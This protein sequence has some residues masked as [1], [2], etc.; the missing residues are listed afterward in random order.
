M[1]QTQENCC[2]FAPVLTRESRSSWLKG[3]TTQLKN[4]KNRKKHASAC[5]MSQHTS[6]VAPASTCNIAISAN[7]CARAWC[8]GALACLRVGLS[9]VQNRSLRLFNILILSHPSNYGRFLQGLAV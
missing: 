6:L 7:R 4:H 9:T 8:V 1:F 2:S 5:A 3:L